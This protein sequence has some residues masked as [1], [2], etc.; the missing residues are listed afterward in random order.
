[1]KRLSVFV[2]IG[3]ALLALAGLLGLLRPVLATTSPPRPASLQAEPAL[4][5]TAPY[6]YYFPRLPGGDA[7]APVST[8]SRYVDSLIP[9]RLQAWGCAAGQQQR[10]GTIILDFGQPYTY[11]ADVQGVYYFAFDVAPLA[12]VELAARSFITGYATC[13][14]P[15]IPVTIGLGVNNYGTDVHFASGLAWGQMTQ[16]IASA[17]AASSYA[18]RVTVMGAIDAEPGFGSAGQTRGW[19]D[20]YASGTG[21]P[22]INFGSC[23]G[24]PTSGAPPLN[25]QIGGFWTLNELWYV[26]GG[27]PLT[28]PLP[29]IYLTSGTNARQW[30]TVALAVKTWANADLRFIGV[31]TQWQACHERGN[32]AECEAIHTNN[33]SEAGWTQLRD[34]LASAPSVAQTF[35]PPTDISWEAWN[36][37]ALANARRI[38]SFTRPTGRALGWGY[39]VASVTAPLPASQFIGVNAWQRRVGAIRLIVHAGARRNEGGASTPALVVF[40]RDDGLG[41]WQRDADGALARYYTPTGAKGSLRIV[42]ARGAVLELRDSANQRFRFDT[43]TFRWVR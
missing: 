12:Q 41:V 16:R 19:V 7:T 22:L 21:R 30:K 2:P 33:P 9:S 29:E 31:M 36:S 3:V 37:S 1:M 23:D 4:A 39:L 32:D 25:T 20:G 11:T 34:A 5:A 17:V 14:P 8:T 15:T 35:G 6:T 43:T 18:S 42:T 38:T 13:A 40:R 26:S 24:C 28:K 10:R 27:H